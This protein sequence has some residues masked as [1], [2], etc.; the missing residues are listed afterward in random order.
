MSAGAGGQDSHGEAVLELA[1]A[2][3]F[4]VLPFIILLFLLY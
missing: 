1:V 2:K 4:I 3:C